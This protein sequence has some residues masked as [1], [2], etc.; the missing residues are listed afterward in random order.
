[1][2]DPLG[3]IKGKHLGVS[4]GRTIPAH[5]GGFVDNT[6]H[7]ATELRC[8]LDPEVLVFEDEMV[9]MERIHTAAA[10]TDEFDGVSHYVEGD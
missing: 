7:S 6:T 4:F 1:M 3:S 2:W 8:H 10:I 5:K 9:N